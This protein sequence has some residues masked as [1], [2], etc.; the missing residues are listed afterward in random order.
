MDPGFTFYTGITTV[1]APG[2]PSPNDLVPRNPCT[3]AGSAPQPRDYA[4]AGN[5]AKGNPINFGRAVVKGFPRGGYLDAQPAASGNALQRAA[6]GNYAF[7]VFMAAAGVPLSWALTG[8]NAYAFLSGAQYTSNNGPM[9]Q[10]YKSL[11]AANVA[12][13]TN[14]YTAQVYGNTC[15]N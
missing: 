9:D 10:N 1:L 7:G 11:P 12:N 5:A 2:G 8:G 14:G 6:Y 15:H 13:V 4:A 3:N